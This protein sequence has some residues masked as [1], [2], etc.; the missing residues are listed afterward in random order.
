M[1]IIINIFYLYGIIYIVQGIITIFKI[2]T[3][4]V[5][6]EGMAHLIPS[7]QDDIDS[8]KN[9]LSGFGKI[10]DESRKENP[11]ST[12]LTRM[13]MLWL[14]IGMFVP[15]EYVIFIVITIISFAYPF[16]GLLFELKHRTLFSVLMELVSIALVGYI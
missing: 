7:S 15:D 1:E 13:G 8:L 2:K 3:N 10:S 14:L 6:I 9:K 11:I 16:V 12:I 4:L 5:T